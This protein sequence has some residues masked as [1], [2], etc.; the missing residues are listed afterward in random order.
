MTYTGTPPNNMRYKLVAETG[1]KGILIKVPYP[2]AGSYSVKADGKFVEP[3]D[4]DTAI[5]A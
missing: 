5:A 4:W 1:T 3:N 2:N